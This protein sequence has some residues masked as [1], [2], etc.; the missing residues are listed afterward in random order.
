MYVGLRMLTAV[1]GGGH[2]IIYKFYFDTHNCETCI[3]ALEN[4]LEPAGPAGRGGGG[5]RGHN[6]V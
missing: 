3:Y 2:C 4:S 1:G 6:Y 5:G